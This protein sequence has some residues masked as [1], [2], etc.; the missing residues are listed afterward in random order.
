MPILLFAGDSPCLCSNFG[1]G[2]L[3]WTTY[4]VGAVRGPE[5]L[6]SSLRSAGILAKPLPAILKLVLNTRTH[7]AQ[8]IEE[9]P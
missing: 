4:G 8:R 2:Y 9:K 7:Q 1:Q 3:N 6:F 5:A